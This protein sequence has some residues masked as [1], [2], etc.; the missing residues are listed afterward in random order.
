MKRNNV[1]ECIQLS[2]ETKV[3]TGLNKT[4]TLIVYIPCTFK[5]SINRPPISQCI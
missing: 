3:I 2:K 4:E 1:I 5:E